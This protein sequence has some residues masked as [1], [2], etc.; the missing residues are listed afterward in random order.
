MCCFSIA[1]TLA[2]SSWPSAGCSSR[3][4]RSSAEWSAAENSLSWRGT[5]RCRETLPRNSK[6]LSLVSSTKH[7]LWVYVT[8]R[9]GIQSFREVINYY[10]P[11]SSWEAYRDRQL[12]TNFELKFFVCHVLYAIC[13]VFSMWG[14]QNP[15]CL[16]PEKRNHLSFVNISPTLVIDTSM[17]RSS[18][19]LRHRNPKI[20]FKKKVRNSNFNLCWRAEINIHVGLNMYLYDDIGDAL[21]SLRGLTSSFSLVNSWN[22]HEVM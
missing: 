10:A 3:K 21:L 15:V 8:V 11:P 17:K 22:D 18:Q 16:Y 7:L 20:W 13:F 9:L 5:L 1:V 6:N 2:S 12:T 4:T 14:F 19:V